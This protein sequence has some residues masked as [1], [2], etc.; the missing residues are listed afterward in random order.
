MAAGDQFPDPWVT[1]DD[2][3]RRQ[4]SD[5]MT[6]V[7]QVETS[8]PSITPEIF[9]IKGDGTDEALKLQ[10]M[11]DAAEG[12]TLLLG[13]G[14]TYSFDP[15]TTRLNIRAN[16]K[17]I[18][19][20]SKFKKLNRDSS[21]SM[22]IAANNVDID[23]LEIEPFHGGT[24]ESGLLIAGSNVRIGEFVCKATSRTGYSSVLFNA[25]Q[26]APA[27][28]TI[29]NIRIGRVECDFW[30]CPVLVAGVEDF[31]I[32]YLDI[33]NYLKAVYVRDAAHGRIRGG[34]IRTAS[35]AITGSPGENGIIMESTTVHGSLHDIY[36][37]NVAVED[38]GEHGFRLGGQLI[39]RNIWYN[40]CRAKNTGL[41][42]G[43]GIEPNNHGG[44]GFKALGPTSITGA[45]HQ[46]IHF[47]N[48]VVE[49]IFWSVSEGKTS[50][51]SGFQL[52]K[53]YG[54]S[55]VNPIVR[56]SIQNGSYTLPAGTYSC[57]NGIEIVGCEEV[58]ITNPIILYPYQSGV[59]FLDVSATEDYGAMSR[60]VVLGGDIK[61]P[62]TACFEFLTRYDTMRRVSISGTFCEGGQYAIKATKEGVGA[63]NG[64]MA[65]VQTHSQT[66]ETF[67]GCDD[68]MISA[69]GQEIGTGNACRDGSQF[70]SWSAGKIKKRD[71]GAW[72]SL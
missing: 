22:R 57:Q 65:T 29:K 61:G 51:F 60:V 43:T 16:T 35:S 8:T 12:Q 37:E 53:I 31:E 5:W 26:I 36:I 58:T 39:A 72:V 63:L 7:R 14:K 47:I 21:F 1:A 46:N 70:N 59:Y 38:S 20:G 24:G 27:S 40:N 52:G 32:G 48:C 64:C 10:A 71:G 28:G 17:I 44:C 45:R 4:L 30:D 15:G 54:G 3:M 67:N 55:V 13:I 66:A 62:G 33:K 34:F 42:T 18:S 25:L 11:F 69:M 2:G 9:G 41:G 50:N 56:K 6:I 68:F 23:R 19:R 49:D